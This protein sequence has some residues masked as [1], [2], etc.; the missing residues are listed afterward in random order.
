MRSAAPAVYFHEETV[1]PPMKVYTQRNPCF[2][3]A[4]CASRPPR[5][6]RRCVPSYIREWQ[7][8]IESELP[9]QWRRRYSSCAVVGSSPSLLNAALG[10]SIDSAEA[11]FR[12]NA[13]PTRGYEAF[14]GARTTV[15]LWGALTREG[16]DAGNVYGLRPASLPP[17]EGELS[18][19][20]CP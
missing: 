6:K 9:R 16:I 12:A 5:R 7:A 13:A 17:G 15:R 14:A 18:V 3:L 20:K 4:E 1:E 8:R 10:R 11:V 2:K 19:V